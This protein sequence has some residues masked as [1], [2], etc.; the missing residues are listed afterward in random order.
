MEKEINRYNS[1]QVAIIIAG[2]YNAHLGP[3]AGPRGVG[4]PNERGLALKKF[5]DRNILFVASHSSTSSGPT[6]TYHSGGHF[7]TVDYII[8]NG[9]Q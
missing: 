6:Y 5:I 2:D 3:L 9:C 1:S 4:M 7:T 8:I